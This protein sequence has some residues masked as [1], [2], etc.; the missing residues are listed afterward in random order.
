[1]RGAETGLTPTVMG[2]LPGVLVVQEALGPSKCPLE[3]RTRR[4][5]A[6]LNGRGSSGRSEKVPMAG[7]AR[8]ADASISARCGRLVPA[9]SLLD[10]SL[11][12]SLSPSTLRPE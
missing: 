11:G 9:P 3:E 2:G 12:E 10:D 6:A 7:E 5:G 8:A 4:G 1:M